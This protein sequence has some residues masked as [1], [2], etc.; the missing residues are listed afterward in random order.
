[1]ENKLIT[2]IK[3]FHDGLYVSLSL[4]MSI[5]IAVTPVVMAII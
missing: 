3:C 5:L 4:H 1:M 2:M